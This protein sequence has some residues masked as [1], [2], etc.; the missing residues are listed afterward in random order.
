MKYTSR[1]KTPLKWL[2]FLKFISLP[3]QILFY[4]YVFVSILMELFGSDMLPHL[5]APV[6]NIYGYAANHLGS[7]FWPILSILLALI[8]LVYWVFEI[9]RGLIKW[10][11]LSTVLWNLYLVVMYVICGGVMVGALMYLPPSTVSTVVMG[12]L[13]NFG[14]KVPASFVSYIPLLVFVVVWLIA[15]IIYVSLNI[16]YFVRR[17]AL[18][19]KDYSEEV[20]VEKEISTVEEVKTEETAPLEA[21]EKVEEESATTETEE[22]SEP[23]SSPTETVE[24]TPKVDPVETEGYTQV[25]STAIE[26]DTAE[27]KEPTH[28]VCKECGAEVLEEDAIFCTNCGKKL[29]K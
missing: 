26:N 2:N 24:E 5:L 25:I 22:Q 14:I 19:A 17:K 11:G 3:I 12:Y 29:E 23:E 8:I 9:E 21:E 6:L 15:G 28:K 13:V 16:I 1:K 18:F 7:A 27:V 10:E 4:I 20:E